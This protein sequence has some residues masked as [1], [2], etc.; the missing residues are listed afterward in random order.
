MEIIQRYFLRDP[1]QDL[2]DASYDICK[3]DY[4]TPRGLY[5]S[6][7]DRMMSIFSKFRPSL[8]KFRQMI[9]ALQLC[10]L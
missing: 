8:A 3:I 6:L 2:H 7:M 10:W 5:C 1:K 4:N 9:G